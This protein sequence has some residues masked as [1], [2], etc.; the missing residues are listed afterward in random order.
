MHS[1]LI[2]RLPGAYEIHY[3]ISTQ[4]TQH[5]QIYHHAY[6][7][8]IKAHKTCCAHSPLIIP[9]I[10]SHELINQYEQFNLNYSTNHTISQKYFMNTIH[11]NSETL[12][13]LFTAKHP[14]IGSL[15]EPEFH[16]H[17][18]P[19][20]HQHTIYSINYHTMSPNSPHP[21]SR[22]AHTALKISHFGSK[23]WD[24]SNGHS[25]PQTNSIIYKTLKQSVTSSRIKLLPLGVCRNSSKLEPTRRPHCV[26][27]LSFVLRR[28]PTVRSPRILERSHTLSH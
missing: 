2:S 4:F 8:I 1:H 13:L 3:V 26:E 21:L 15:C 10:S 22:T 6:I 27:R 23:F 7:Y 5:M 11:V 28:N 24:R 17:F 16:G 19:H 12:G 9:K 25:R 20:T 18:R 14:I